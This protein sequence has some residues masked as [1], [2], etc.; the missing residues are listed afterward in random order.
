MFQQIETWL[1]NNNDENYPIPPNNPTVV[2]PKNSSLQI[3]LL[4]EEIANLRSDNNF[5]SNTNSDVMRQIDTSA[6]TI[7]QLEQE[8]SKDRYH[9]DQLNEQLRQ[10]QYRMN[11][12]T[13]E[14]KNLLHSWEIERN[15]LNDIIRE[16]ERQAET[17]KQV[18]MVERDMI[19]D[20]AKSLMVRHYHYLLSILE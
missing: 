10:L 17:E 20:N 3:D 13:D 16:K 18:I 9:V 12:Q 15:K 5:L 19:S 11:L 7:T 14:Q 4:R 2:V 1:G 8:I 6:I